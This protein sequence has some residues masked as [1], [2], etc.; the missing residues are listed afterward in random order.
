MT[1][2]SPGTNV[3]GSD[4]LGGDIL[5]ALIVPT[6]GELGDDGIALV[7]EGV[8]CLGDAAVRPLRDDFGDGTGEGHDTS[9]ED[10]ED[11]GETHGEETGE[12]EAGEGYFG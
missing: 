7:A 3:D 8:E 4:D 2:D 10:S 9:S 5:R 6:A 11:S 1:A 12:E